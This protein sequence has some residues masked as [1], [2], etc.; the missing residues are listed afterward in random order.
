MVKVELLQGL[1]RGE[2]GGADAALAAMALAGGD[3]A[4]QAGDEE[5][6]RPRLRPGAFGQP[7]DRLAQRGRLLHPGQERDL[8][9]NI[10]GSGLG[11]RAGRG[12]HATDPSVQQL[13]EQFSAQRATTVAW[14]VDGIRQRGT[15]REGTTRRHAID[16]VWLLMDP[17]VYQRLICYRGW[18]AARYERW[19]VD[20]VARLLV[21]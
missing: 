21:D 12:H 8:G 10:T 4:L 1:A 6:L 11:R 20:A 19:F 15:L 9:A 7:G 3:L 16:Q 14:I 2:A 18:S 5:L 17:A 13:A